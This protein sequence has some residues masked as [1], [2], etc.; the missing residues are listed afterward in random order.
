MTK[1]PVP[2]KILLTRDV[3]FRDRT[4]AITHEFKIGDILVATHDMQSGGYFVTAVGG[5][6]HDEARRI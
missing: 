4:D 2:F 1:D 6:Y 3:T 5:I